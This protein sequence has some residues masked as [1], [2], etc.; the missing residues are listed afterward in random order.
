MRS[1]KIM[2]TL[3]ITIN[4]I[5]ISLFIYK[6]Y[7]RLNPKS[8]EDV[9]TLTYWQDKFSE[10]KILNQYI[11]G[12]IIFLGDS[13]VDR[14]NL[15]E[16]FPGKNILNRG[17][18]NDDSRSLLA[19]LND[20]AINAHPKK[21]YIFIGTND[22]I[23]KIPE[24]ETISNLEKIYKKIITNKITLNVIFLLPV[25]KTSGI[26]NK[27]ITLLNEHIFQLCKK[28][29][30]RYFNVYEKFI[31]EEMELRKELTNDGLHLNGNGYLVFVKY[32]KSFI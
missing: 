23:H 18:G 11:K 31:D 15:N 2:L 3:S 29:N 28:L 16:F 21:I 9:T 14:F 24:S 17:I 27:K 26:N 25:R 6:I 20:N 10:Y 5:F 4:L 32:F 8:I 30:I 22:I 12:N 7:Y 19:R 13:F 1:I